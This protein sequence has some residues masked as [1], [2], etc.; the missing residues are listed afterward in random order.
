MSVSRY[1][2]W[3]LLALGVATAIAATFGPATRWNGVDIGAPG[4]A[5]FMI[6]LAG[7]IWLFAARGDALF[8]D[9][10]SVTERRAWVGLAFVGVVL[11]VFVRHLWA[12]SENAIVPVSHH[13]FFGQQFVQRL[14]VLLVVWSVIFHLIGRASGGIE[15]DE[16]DLR[17][18]HRADRAGDWALTLIV[19]AC[20]TV[21]ASVPEAHLAW[22]LAPIVLANVFIGLL[23]VK[24]FVEHA[25]L[26][27]AYRFGGG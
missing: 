4:A 2:R 5:L 16:R 22:W 8:P 27:C 1:L 20:I 15:T 14:L 17:L 18:R 23:I 6:V 10:M 26:A 3:W 21:L 25:A 9:D 24:S 13:E 7:A 19:I 12:L 11:L